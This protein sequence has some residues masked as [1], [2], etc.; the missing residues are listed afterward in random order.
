LVGVLV[1]ALQ[2]EGAPVT[3]EPSRN[4]GVGESVREVLVAVVASG[5]TQA[6]NAGLKTFSDRIK[7]SSTS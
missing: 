6:I 1:D 5:T 2:D 7:G 4:E 3:W